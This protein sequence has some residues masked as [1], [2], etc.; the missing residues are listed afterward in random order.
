MDF[1]FIDDAQQNSP[2]RPGM[3][4]LSAIGGIHI[5]DEHVQSLEAG[6]SELCRDCGFPSNEI[7]KWSPQRDSWMHGNLTGH[8]REDFYRRTLALATDEGASAI[9]VIEDVTSRRASRAR[10]VE[11][12]LINLFVERAHRELIRRNQKGVV[13]VSQPSGDRRAENKFLAECLE[14]I[15]MGTEYI[16]PDRIALN[17]LS[18]PCR[19]IRLLQLADLITSCTTAYV[20][21]ENIYSPPIFGCI[22]RM[23][24]RGESK[25]VIGGYGLKIH[26]DIKYG[27]LYHWLVADSHIWK[28]CVGYPLPYS[29]LPY[30]EGPD[31]P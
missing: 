3:E 5:P 22:Q 11:L 30:Y 13:I 27:N 1:F 20:A 2:S 29:G 23:F 18:A 12:D 16:I 21:G 19:F 26:P 6:L 7:F 14:T 9:V 25:Q 28:G 8:A 10:T 17:F 15:E 31:M 4:P 24:I